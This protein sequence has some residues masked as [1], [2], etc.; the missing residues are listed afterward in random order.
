MPLYDKPI[1][2]LVVY[3]PPLTREA[4]FADFWQVTLQE[5]SQAPLNAEL[6]TLDYPARCTVQ[7]LTHDGW[8]ER[9]SRHGTSRRSRGTF[10]GLVAVTGT[11]GAKPMSGHSPWAPGSHPGRRRARAIWREHRPGTVS[12]RHAAPMTQGITDPEAY[13]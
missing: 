4:D 3:K 1:E 8:Q 9:A 13:Y 10:P 2:E 6:E 11:A 7:K 12:R 5:A